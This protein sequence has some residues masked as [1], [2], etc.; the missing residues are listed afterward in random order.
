MVDVNFL[1][2][3]YVSSHLY[4][5]NSHSNEQFH[6]LKTPTS[7]HLKSLFVP[8]HTAAPEGKR[9]SLVIA[10]EWMAVIAD[11]GPNVMNWEGIRLQNNRNLASALTQVL[12]PSRED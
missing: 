8:T 9:R 12:L 3:A 2:A 11:R 6:N 10:D 1:H 4:E 7:P 5:N